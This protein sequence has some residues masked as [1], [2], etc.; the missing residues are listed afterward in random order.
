MRVGVALCV[1]VLLLAGCATGF[2]ARSQQ[3]L[4]IGLETTNALLV[5]EKQN[6][7]TFEKQ[8]PGVHAFAEQVRLKFPAFFKAATDAI[9][10][11]KAGKATQSDVVT[12]VSVVN[13]LALSAQ[14]YL[15]RWGTK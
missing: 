5:V 9:D 4:T 1:A 7:A 11:Y 13:S 8:A 12:A 15:A 3:T 6:A 10:A 14:A 2:V